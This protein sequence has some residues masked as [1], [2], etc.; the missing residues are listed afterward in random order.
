MRLLEIKESTRANKKWM[1]LIEKDGKI[2]KR[3]FG[4]KGYPDYT[5]PPHSDVKRNLYILRHSAN[6]S[7]NDPTTPATLSRFLLW[8]KKTLPEAIK[9]YKK[10]FN[11]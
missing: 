8:E 1:A 4:A 2:L 3:H 6:E 5:T 11:I 7:F 9:H 10:I